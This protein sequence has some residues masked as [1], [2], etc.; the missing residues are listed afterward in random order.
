M[1][2]RLKTKLETE[3]LLNELQGKLQFS[4]KAAVIRLAVSFSL[5]KKGDPRIVSGKLINYDSK[6]QDGNDY[7]RYTLL[8][9]DETLYKLL[10][11]EHLQMEISDDFFPVLLNAHLERGIRLLNSEL[12]YTGNKEKFFSTLLKG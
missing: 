8:G 11:S 10:F 9:N 2:I 3:K 7:M 12:K 6:K 5:Q 1:N 4:T